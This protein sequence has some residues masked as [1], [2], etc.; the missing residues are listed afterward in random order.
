MVL[1]S[2]SKLVC[3][4]ALIKVP[5]TVSSGQLHVLEDSPVLVGQAFV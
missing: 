4:F 3:S 1:S 5:G 2:H